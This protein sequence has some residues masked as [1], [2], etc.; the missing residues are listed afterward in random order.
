ML[1]TVGINVE[2]NQVLPEK[3]RATLQEEKGV[4][5][6][7]RSSPRADPHLDLYRQLHAKGGSNAYSRV[8]I[9][10]VNRLL[11]EAVSVYDIVMAAEMY[12]QAQKLVVQEAVHIPMK[13]DTSFDAIGSR[14]Q[15]WV[16]MP[17]EHPRLRDLWFKTK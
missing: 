10:E 16:S 4:F 1:R 3:Y 5:A 8:N 17:D 7:Y 11:D 15:G 13:Y 6:I 2:F 14:V 12:V 9:P